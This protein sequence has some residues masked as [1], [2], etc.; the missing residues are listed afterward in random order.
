MITK[1]FLLNNGKYNIDCMGYFPENDTVKGFVIGVHGF[2]GDKDSSALRMFAGEMTNDDYVLFC[3]D[4]PSHGKSETDSSELTVANCKTDLL[5]LCKYAETLFPV[6]DK[7]IFATSFGGYIT[8]LCMQELKN[9][10]IILRAPAVTMPEHILTDILHISSEKLKSMKSIICGFDRK[11]DIAYAFY[12]ELQLNK[13]ANVNF[14][15]EMLIIHGNA[16]NIVPPE[17]IEKFCS[18]NPSIRLCVIDGADHRFKK[19]GELKEVIRA[20]KKYY[21]EK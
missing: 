4:F 9:Y 6:T 8:L 12:E 16:D 20:A 18:V 19:P 15:R 2:L 11:V 3:F 17:D 13:V 21:I 1:S 10:K 7:C 5:C 14:D